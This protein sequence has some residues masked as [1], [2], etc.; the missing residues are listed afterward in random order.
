M[1]RQ[2]TLS[3]I[4]S[5]NRR[6][7]DLWLNWKFMP[8][9]L[10]SYLNP[11]H[12]SWALCFKINYSRKRKVLLWSTLCL[13]WTCDCH[14]CGVYVFLHSSHCKFA[15][16]NSTTNVYYKLVLF[17]T[18]FWTVILT[19][20]LLEC[21]SVQMKLASII[22]TLFNPFTCLRQSARSCGDSNAHATHGGL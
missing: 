21:G 9:P 1:S 19:L 14:K 10:P 12:F 6:A 15:I 8:A 11:V 20:S 3:D 2:H 7:C 16:T 18:S 5:T 17:I 22:L 13:T 4:K